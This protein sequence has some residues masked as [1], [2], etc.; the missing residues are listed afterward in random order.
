VPQGTGDPYANAEAAERL[1]R[2]LV[3]RVKAAEQG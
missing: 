2:E 3:R 1:W